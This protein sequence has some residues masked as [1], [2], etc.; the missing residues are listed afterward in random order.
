MNFMARPMEF[1]RRGTRRKGSFPS[2][3][4]TARLVAVV[5]RTSHPSCEVGTVAAV[6]TQVS[7]PCTHACMPFVFDLSQSFLFFWC[8]DL[9]LGGPCATHF[10]DTPTP[11]TI[12]FTVFLPCSFAPY[13]IRL[14]FFFFIFPFLHANETK[15]GMKSTRRKKKR[16]EKNRNR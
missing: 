11:L 5:D 7:L 2:T 4:S 8:F 15:Q 10:H 3:V 13:P 16:E 1:L 14:F 6:Q 9:L 12:L